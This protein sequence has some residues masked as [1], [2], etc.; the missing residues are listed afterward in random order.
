MCGLLCALLGATEV[1]PAR[2]ADE[3]NPCLRADAA[4]EEQIDELIKL[5]AERYSITDVNNLKPWMDKVK[6]TSK[7]TRGEVTKALKVCR[8]DQQLGPRARRAASSRLKKRRRVLDETDNQMMMMQALGHPQ[9][10][11]DPSVLRVLEK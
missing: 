9:P 8:D 3:K 4:T 10:R 1:G 6:E 2:P 7:N 5:K 11:I